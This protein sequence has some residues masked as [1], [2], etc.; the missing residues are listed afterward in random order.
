MLGRNK[1][2]FD[3]DPLLVAIED[4]NLLLRAHFAG[5]TISCRRGEDALYR[6][7]AQSSIFARHGF[8]GFMRRIYYNYA[9]LGFEH[10]LSPVKLYSLMTA[11]TLYFYLLRLLRRI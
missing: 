9:K 1:L 7:N 3:A 8:N 11:S 10:S 5:K 6:T 2:L 4:Y